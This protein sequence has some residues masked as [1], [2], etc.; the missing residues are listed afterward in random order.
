MGLPMALRLVDAGFSVLGWNRSQEPRNVLAA[1][2]GR[3]GEEPREIVAPTILSILPDVDQLESLLE[4]PSGLLAGL[5]TARAAGEGPVV[6]RLIVM[7]TTSPEKVQALA[8]KLKPLRI[9][10]LDAPVSGGDR[11]A[12]QGTL[13]I[14][15]GGE[16][17]DI[18]EVMPILEPLGTLIEHMGPAG[19]GSMAKLCNQIV[20][21]GNLTAT[22]EAL[23]VAESAGLDMSTM[24]RL[25]GNGL[26]RSG[27]LELKA[28]KW[29]SGRYAIGGSAKNQ[30]KDLHYLAQELDRMNLDAPVARLL[31]HTFERIVDVGWGDYDH[32]VVLELLRGTTSTFPKH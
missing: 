7:S 9:H 6:V 25:F 26:S 30:L 4:G 10:V 22:A 3:A 12:Q 8:N 31:T 20:V 27:V 29:L 28:D 32:A 2:G 17:A 19:S 15:V 11:G 21:A 1:R 5:E 23:M 18:R 16:D 13:S 24:V 14:M